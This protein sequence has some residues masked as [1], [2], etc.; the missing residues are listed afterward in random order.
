MLAMLLG[1]LPAHFPSCRVHQRAWVES[2]ERWGAFRTPPLDGISLTE[3]P[4]DM[5]IALRHGTEHGGRLLSRIA[6]GSMLLPAVFLP[7]TSDLSSSCRANPHLQEE[8]RC[9]LL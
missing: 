7:A 4:C 9:V 8:K 6:L 2:L 1:S 5:C 3:D